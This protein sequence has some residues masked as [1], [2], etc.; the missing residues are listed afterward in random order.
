MATWGVL[1]AVK[2]SR[3]DRILFTHLAATGPGTKRGEGLRGLG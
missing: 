3:N 2:L 1:K